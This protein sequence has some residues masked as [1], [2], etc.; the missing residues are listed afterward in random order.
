MEKEKFNND[1]FEI[2][3]NHERQDAIRKKYSEKRKRK[4]LKILNM[5]I[6]SGVISLFFG[7]IGLTGAMNIYI[8]SP[9]FS[10]C[11]LLAAFLT[12]RWFENG[13]CLGWE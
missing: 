8:S 12:G 4:N 1:I 7:I 11:G 5:A 2:V 6:I 10:L 3:N 9:I 13:K